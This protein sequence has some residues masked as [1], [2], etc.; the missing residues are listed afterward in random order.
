MKWIILNKLKHLENYLYHYLKVS[1][2]Y[3]SHNLENLHYY[4]RSPEDF[5]FFKPDRALLVTNNIE[6]NEKY[7]LQIAKK[8]N[9]LVS[10]ISEN[11]LLNNELLDS[12]YYI[13]EKENYLDNKPAYNYNYTNMHL[14]LPKILNWIKRKKKGV[15]NFFNLEKHN[16]KIDIKDNY[17]KPSEGVDI[18]EDIVCLDKAKKVNIY[19]PSYYRFEKTKKSI[20]DMIEL[21]K[22]SIHDIKI[23]IGDNN[24]KIKEMREWLFKI[25]KEKE[26]IK[27]YFSDN[28]IGK[29]NIINYMDKN[30]A[31]QDYDYLFSIDSDMVIDHKTDIFD[32]MIEIL[33]TGNNIGLV[34]S[35]QSELSQHWYG[36]TVFT[37]KSRGF[38]LGFTNNGIGISGGCILMKKSD[39][40][41]V[42]GYKID[43][44]IYTG[45]DSILTYN[46]FRILGKVA[47]IAHD[48]ILKHPK[49]EEDEKGY[50]DWK[51]ESW[52]RDNINFIKDNYKGSN[53]KG[54]FD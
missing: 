2:D 21:S 33:E 27:V 44:D 12:V 36:K 54:Y 19:M 39:W 32:K 47:V 17:I 4:Y 38:N 14:A 52:K 7:F 26:I 10:L 23:Y 40:Q 48:C 29:A 16:L 35:N 46:V 22:Y 34:A 42:G 15:F 3:K 53:V 49:G 5:L 25:D 51:M 13:N 37:R 30:I 28:N 50:T 9:I 20:L 8:N 11:L 24:T 18:K 6:D 43:H 31:R 41:K 1:E 45:D